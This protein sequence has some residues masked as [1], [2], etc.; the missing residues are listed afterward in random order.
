[1]PTC[2]RS[3]EMSIIIIYQSNNCSQQVFPRFIRENWRTSSLDSG[4]NYFLHYHIQFHVGINFK[5]PSK[6]FSR[7]ELNVSRTKLKNYIEL[8]EKLSSGELI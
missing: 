6:N 5:T 7:K 1:M 3:R 2:V 4:I 8:F